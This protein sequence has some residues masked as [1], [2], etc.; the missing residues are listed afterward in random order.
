M[1]SERA[2]SISFSAPPR[3]IVRLRS[4]PLPGP[5]PAANTIAS[6]PGTNGAMSCS[7]SRSQTIASAPTASSSPA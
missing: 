3:S 2:A 6:A 7:N 4:A 1:P 5:A